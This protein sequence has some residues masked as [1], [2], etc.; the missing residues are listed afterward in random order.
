M[1]LLRET[2]QLFYKELLIEWKLK[3]AFQGLLL[4]LGSSIF[5]SFY[6]YQNQMGALSPL[7]WMV[8]YWLLMLFASAQAVQKTFLSEGQ[9]RQW[10]MQTLVSAEA[11]ILS[12]AI[13]NSVL[14][15][16]VG[17][18]GLGLTAIILGNPVQDMGLFLL[19]V[20]AAIAGFSIVLTM[21]SAIAFK[22]GTNTTLIAVLSFPLLIPLLILVAQTGRNALDGLDWSFSWPGL[23]MLWCFDIMMLLLSFILFPYLWRS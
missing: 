5:L 18:L 15:I 3:Y 4:F 21:A 8:L 12:K 17:F 10:F 14:N 7:S 20:P 9:G 1:I 23:L 16:V 6:S 13:Y 22:T 2:T 11:L 19:L